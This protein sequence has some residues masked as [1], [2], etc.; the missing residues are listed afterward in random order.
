MLWT[1][2][3]LQKQGYTLRRAETG[4]LYERET[5]YHG[6]S[7]VV[8]QGIPL[9]T[10]ACFD[11][12]QDWMGMA[13]STRLGGI[14]QGYLAEMNLGWNQGD[15][16]ETVRENYRRLCKGLGVKPDRLVFSDQ[17]H[18]TTVE[19]VTDHLCAGVEIQKKLVGV[20][21]LY[22]DQT[23][24]V[25]ATSFADCVPLFFADPVRKIIAS[26]HSGWRGTVGQIG[27]HTIKQMQ[28]QFGC[29]PE[30]IIVLIGPSICQNC[31]EVSEDVIRQ[32][33]AVYSEVE[34]ADIVEKGAAKGKYQLDLWAA[35][36]HTMKKAGILPENIQVSGICTCCHAN[37]LFS[38]RATKGKRGN[39]NGFIWK[40][41]G[42]TTPE[43]DW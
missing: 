8:Q 25:L 23:D 35:C 40:H 1:E 21:G 26:S 6:V 18:E 10:F 14:S 2:E 42:L 15:A 20:D 36:Y 12:Q 43:S 9:L 16:P 28:R 17:I 4:K 32:F 31:Y 33:E 30:D 7:L 22:T 24:V 34:L 19:Y 11:G 5:K 37:L 13:F 41:A 27:L 38:H 3:L 29:Q 39:L